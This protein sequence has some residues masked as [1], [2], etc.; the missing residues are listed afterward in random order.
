MYQ[1]TF[2]LGRCLLIALLYGVA[3][4]FI[5]DASM[6]SISSFNWVLVA[7][8]RM[9]C[10]LLIPMRYWPAL[11]M[12]EAI[13]L[14]YANYLCLDA[15]GW[16]WV[17]AASV[18]PMLQVMPVVAL[19]RLRVPDIQSRIAQKMTYLLACMFAA[20][21]ITTLTAWLDYRLEAH[22][23]AGE[24]PLSFIELAGQAFAG[25]YL[26]MLSFTPLA[27]WAAQVIKCAMGDRALAKREW[28]NF[29]KRRRYLVPSV[30]LIVDGLMVLLALHSDDMERQLVTFGILATLIPV[31]ASY[32]WPGIALMGAAANIALVSIMPV[33]NDTVTLLAQG[34]MVLFMT[35]LFLF[36]AQ[37]SKAIELVRDEFVQQTR[38]GYLMT[39][40][41]RLKSACHL[42]D[43]LDDAR[44]ETTRLMHSARTHMPAKALV[45]HYHRL[46]ILHQECSRIL[47][48]L[49][50]HDWWDFGDRDGLIISALRSEG[51]GCDVLAMPRNAHLL[52]LSTDMCI[53]IHRLGCEMVLHVLERAPSNRISL[54]L[55][56]HKQGNGY[57]IEM[58]VEST[59]LPF[60]LG[61]EADERLMV[62]IGAFGLSEQGLRE[63]AQL[64]E[65]D[66]AMTQVSRHE[67]RA[68][69]RMIDR[70]DRMTTLPSERRKPVMPDRGSP[71]GEYP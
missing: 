70:P 44:R 50:P 29:I 16:P 3:Y 61:E 40:R 26:A 41:V 54:A 39:E 47:M 43:A 65:G 11:V 38:R 53:T 52:Q 62:S 5:R 51:I 49:S 1:R 17:W 15:F 9:S 48:G 12:G 46:D 56:I 68:V 60:I 18:P 13:P 23:P 20:A 31:A 57:H 2:Y 7:A 22:L 28:I 19:T 71:W 58:V 55:G 69:L 67:A 45:E 27:L 63:R 59:G 42:S 66:V 33:Y 6:R 32:G 14:G 64:Y 10:L 8:L 35:T 24:R 21:V 36:A 30:L 25:Y 4:V 37:S 34:F